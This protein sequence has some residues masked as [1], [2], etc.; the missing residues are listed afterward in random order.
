MKQKYA[1]VNLE[2]RMAFGP[3]ECWIIV[4][5]AHLNRHGIASAKFYEIAGC[6]ASTAAEECNSLLLSEEGPCSEKKTANT[7][8]VK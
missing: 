5:L 1:P 2:S 6:L 8:S 7:D 4:P 3:I